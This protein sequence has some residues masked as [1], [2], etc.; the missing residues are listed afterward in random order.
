M[1]FRYRESTCT[2]TYLG[3]L[4]EEQLALEREQ[5]L[6]KLVA[7]SKITLARM[8]NRYADANAK[9]H[10]NKIILNEERMDE[11]LLIMRDEGMVFDREMDLVHAAKERVATKYR[12][13][14]EK[15]AMHVMCTYE[16]RMRRE[17]EMEEKENME[18]RGGLISPPY[19]PQ[20]ERKKGRDRKGSVERRGR[21]T[22]LPSP[23]N[24]T[25]AL[26]DERMAKQ[27]KY[28]YDKEQKHLFDTCGYPP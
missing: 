7:S 14:D 20:P 12:E 5:K 26:L 23:E 21:M 10:A 18:K 22:P 11:E 6:V 25:S 16:V 28:G 2:P 1:T 4:T 8:Y 17:S 9:D 3:D 27:A 19:S 24:E 15:V 13:R